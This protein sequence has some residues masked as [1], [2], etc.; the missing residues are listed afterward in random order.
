MRSALESAVLYGIC[1]LGYVSSEKAEDVS[2]ALLAGGVGILQL[3]AKGH[4]PS[5]LRDLALRLR[6][7]CDEFKTPLVINDHLELAL[8]CGAHGLHL[9]QDDGSLQEARERIGP[10]MLLGRSTHSLR[11]AR[12]ALADNADYIGFGPLFPTPTQIN[13]I[14]LPEGTTFST[15]GLFASTEIEQSLEASFDYTMLIGSDTDFTT[16][17]STNGLTD[18]NAEY[19]NS[20][21][22]N[23][24]AYALGRDLNPNVTPALIRNGDLIGFSHRQR[25]VGGQVRYQVEKSTDLVNWLPAGDLSPDGAAIEN[26]DGTFTVN[27]LSDIPTSNRDK[28]YFRLVVSAF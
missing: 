17:M 8:E 9:G 4:D 26:Q 2:R 23:L 25:I 20:G 12:Q 13:Q 15:G 21:L 1:D 24:M 18:P 16:W 28:I 19:E 14:T 7:L 11:Q 22:K 5:S 3:R 6:I 10:E 27:L